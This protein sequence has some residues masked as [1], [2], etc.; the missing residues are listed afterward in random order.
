[1]SGAEVTAFGTT[2][3]SFLEIATCP[4][5]L[6]LL[7]ETTTYIESRPDTLSV[8]K[9]GDNREANVD[10][11]DSEHK[12]SDNID[13]KNFELSSINRGRGSISAEE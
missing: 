7:V 13:E 1:M 2:H 5:Q 6:F 12:N 10:A 8:K 4:T 3:P 9:V 11:E